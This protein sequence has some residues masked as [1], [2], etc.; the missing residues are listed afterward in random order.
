MRELIWR[1][2]ALGEAMRRNAC[3]ARCAQTFGP[4]GRRLLRGNTVSDDDI[5]RETDAFDR[6]PGG[7]AAQL[8][9]VAA[10]SRCWL[11]VVSA[12]AGECAVRLHARG[13]YCGAGHFAAAA[14]SVP[15]LISDPRRAATLRVEVAA[16]RLSACRRSGIT[17]G[18]AAAVEDAQ[19]AVALCGDSSRAHHVSA[20]S[21]ETIGR[22]FEACE[23]L[24]RALQLC[25]RSD[26]RLHLTGQLAAARS[27]A[28][29]TP[30]VT[31]TL[32]VG[33]VQTQIWTE[34]ARRIRADA[35]LAGLV[36]SLAA[37]HLG[38][39]ALFRAD[40][41]RIA[42]GSTA[43]GNGLRDGDALHICPDEP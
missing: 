30:D 18:C 12:A 31:L 22:D 4:R 23:E 10:V 16:A 14:L 24:R 35:A 11:A 13:D 40:G 5:V 9:S 7:L 37:A 19:N 43:Q 41:R 20:L 36:D 1:L 33:S 17:D 27:R 3:G 39:L 28:G 38:P 25:S 6:A 21:L 15:C 42:P 34:S 2:G 8:R 32:R 26:V 29:S